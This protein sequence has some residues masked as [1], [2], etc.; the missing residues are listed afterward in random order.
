MSFSESIEEIQKY[1][2]DVRQI[3][4]EAGR[5]TRFVVMMNRAF[6]ESEPRTINDLPASLERG[7]TYRRGKSTL[8]RRG[9]VDAMLGHAILEF[10]KDLGSGR[11]TALDELRKYAAGLTSAA[12]Q[13]EIQYIGFATDGVHFER[14]RLWVEG[15]L[16]IVVDHVQADLT[17]QFELTA[18]RESAVSFYWWAYRNLFQRTDRE[19]T[20]D[21]FRRDFG[22][23]GVVYSLAAQ[24]LQ[25]AWKNVQNQ[26]DVDL[27]YTQWAKYLQYSHGEKIDKEGESLYLRHTYL[28]CLA[29]FMVWSALKLKQGD[30]DD[31]QLIEGVLSGD[32]LESQAKVIGAADRDPFH[33]VLKDSVIQEMQTVWM[34]LLN[35]LKSYRL[36]NLKTDVLKALYEELVHPADRHM[37]GEYYT[38]DWLCQKVVDHVL[39]KENFKRGWPTVLDPTCGS[40]SFLVS[41]IHKMREAHDVFQTRPATRA[42]HI[43][44]HVIG[45]EIHP[46]AVLIAKTNYLLALGDDL[47]HAIKSVR[48]PV[49]LA[50][51]MIDPDDMADVKQMFN[52][53]TIQIQIGDPPLDPVEVPPMLADQIVYDGFIDAVVKESF[54]R[55]NG[56]ELSREAIRQTLMRYDSDTWRNAPDAWMDEVEP[57]IRKLGEQMAELSRRGRNT[58]WA[59]IARNF[60]R[61]L[62]NQRV[63]TTVV[64]NPPWLA[65]RYI[66]NPK[67]KKKLEKLALNHYGVCSNESKLRT[68]TEV[69]TTFLLHACNAYLRQGGGGQIAF[70]LPRSV[71]SADQHARLRE[72]PIGTEAQGFRVTELWDLAGVVPLFN[73][74]SCVVFGDTEVR[75]DNYALQPIAGVDA[76]GRFPVREAELEDVQTN[77]EWSDATFNLVHLGQRNAW[78]SNPEQPDFKGRISAYQDKFF[79]GATIVPRNAFFVKAYDDIPAWSEADYHDKL[80][81]IVTEPEQAKTAKEPWKSLTF[82]GKVQRRFLFKTALAKHILP[83][84]LDGD[85]PDVVLPLAINNKGQ[86]A[87]L[88]VPD[89]RQKGYLEAAEYFEAVEKAYAK[90]RKGAASKRTETIHDQIDYLGKLTKQNF[91]KKWVVLYARS[92]TNVSCCL[93][94]VASHF[95]LAVD[96]ATYRYYAASLTEAHYLL[97]V[98]NSRYLNEIIKPFQSRGLQGERDIHKK[99]LEV[100]FPQFNSKKKLHTDLAELGALCTKKAT[101]LQTKL[102]KKTT[103]ARRTEIRNLLEE[104]LDQIDILVHRLF[105]S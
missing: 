101:K 31:H 78:T 79:Q 56:R 92:G 6:G 83:F 74:P 48:I 41:S 90:H 36:A 49:Y 104:E 32:I 86:G 80:F 61:P 42:A 57:S 105:L 62:L 100:P 52:K 45:F 59:F 11:K 16:A 88:S 77:L 35:E 96:N 9:R 91:K 39:P 89:M 51:S 1:A 10:K 85:L 19:P 47:D 25:A 75:D 38:P 60:W 69:A 43:T 23:S 103:G 64:G 66:S 27:A 4:S 55:L 18:S 28:A 33:W 22:Q 21:A 24:H 44:S 98:I 82:K 81:A 70:V 37:L 73:V 95:K 93:V 71:F 29:K 58:I 5:V 50:D 46:L 8:L 20:A 67:Y 34:K 13:D 54:E 17:D 97:A 15:E 2:E 40:G 99:L 30:L 14:Y 26:S 7:V 68:Q 53:G 87:L 94:K 84:T 3:Q 72:G 63:F 102:T 12:N 76:K 65:F